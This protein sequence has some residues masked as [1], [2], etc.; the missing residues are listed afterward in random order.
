MG[1][2][3]TVLFSHHEKKRFIVFIKSIGADF[4]ES[5]ECYSQSPVDIDLSIGSVITDNNNN[6]NNNKIGAE[7]DPH[8]N[9]PTLYFMIKKPHIT[10][11]EV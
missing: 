11:I 5:T 2:Y 4:L 3:S 1:V 6:N 9:R 8:P 7:A 10:P